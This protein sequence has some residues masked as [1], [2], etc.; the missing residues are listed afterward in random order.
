MT[1]RFNLPG[2]QFLELLYLAVFPTALAYLFWDQA[3][4]H[5]NKNLVTAF[6]YFT[7]LGSTLIS[8]LYLHVTIGTGFGLAALLVISGAFLCKWSIDKKIE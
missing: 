1:P 5:G 3:M 6:S 4:K 8:G 2:Y 7:P